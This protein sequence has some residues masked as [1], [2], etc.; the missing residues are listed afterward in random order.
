[1]GTPKVYLYRQKRIHDHTTRPFVKNFFPSGL[2]YTYLQFEKN[3]QLTERRN[4]EEKLPKNGHSVQIS[5]T[6]ESSDVV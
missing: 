2:F 5:T 6:W 1:M 3:A 4:V